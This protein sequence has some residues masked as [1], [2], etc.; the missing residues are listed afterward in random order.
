V[1][2][3]WPIACNEYVL[4]ESFVPDAPPEGWYP[5]LEPVTPIGDTYLMVVLWDRYDNGFFRPRRQ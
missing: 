5:V 3:W 4:E 1:I 2:L